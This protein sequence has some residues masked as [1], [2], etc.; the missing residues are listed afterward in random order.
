MNKELV[1]G[2]GCFWCTEAIFQRLR[3]VEAVVSGYAGGE[4]QPS[5]W[6]V[7]RG[8]TNHAEAVKIT[9]DSKQITNQELLEVF[10]ATHDPTSLNRQGFDRG[11]QYRSAIF[12]QSQAERETVEE[13]ISQLDQSGAYSKP[14]VTTVEDLDQFYTAEEYHQNFYDSNRYQPYCLLVV[15]P[16]LDKLKKLFSDK[17]KDEYK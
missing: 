14:I 13:Y 2:G 15:D 5:Y 10:F 9:Y 1:V 3:G 16:K 17:L 8:K 11:K 4:D 7:A 12:V 6:E